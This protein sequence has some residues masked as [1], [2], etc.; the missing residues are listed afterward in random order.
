MGA[1]GE[2]NHREATVTEPVRAPL[3]PACGSD[4]LFTGIE[5]YLCRRRT[6]RVISWDPHGDPLLADTVVRE[7][8]PSHVEGLRTTV[9]L[10]TPPGD[11]EEASLMQRSLVE[12]LELPG[13][14]TLGVRE[15]GLLMRAVIDMEQRIAD[16]A[17]RDHTPGL[18]MVSALRPLDVLIGFAMS[19]ADIP[20]HLW[21]PDPLAFLAMLAIDATEASEPAAGV[22]LACSVDVLADGRWRIR[23]G[24]GARS[25]RSP[26]RV[27]Y[28]R[29]TDGR[30]YLVG[31][32][33]HCAHPPWLVTDAALQR[34]LADDA[35][36]TW[37]TRMHR[38]GLA[39][40]LHALVN[41]KAP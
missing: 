40:A 20:D 9:L 27:L 19:R 22:A 10:K 24:A 37:L 1:L 15:S 18:Y 36:H 6:C 26:L 16:E 28:C 17:G 2:L 31:R 35:V 25:G 4:P 12:L 23:T 33:G 14:P 29:D 3:C 11:D 30:H 34:D 38:T 32:R 41:R 7:V 8:D 39:E 21:H 5:P 13:P